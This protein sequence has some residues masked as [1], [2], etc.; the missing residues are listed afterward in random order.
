MSNM[1]TEKRERK[2]KTISGQIVQV[3]VVRFKDSSKEFEEMF[4]VVE[5]ENVSLNDSFM[6]YNPKTSQE[7]RVKSSIIKAKETGM[8]NFRK[9]AMDPSFAD[10][11]KTIIYCTGKKPAVGGLGNFWDEIFK[12]FIPEKNSRLIDDLEKDVSLGVLIKY[13]VEKRKYKVR[14]AWKTVCVN[15]KDIAHCDNSKDAKHEFEETG[16]R[17]IGKWF[18]LGNTCKIVKKREGSGYLIFGTCYDYKNGNLADVSDIGF[19]YDD[20]NLSVGE[21]VMDV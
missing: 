6:Q 16:S 11:D 14:K 1:T 20:C 10:D 19:P 2:L 12:N 7:K 18:D 17:P 3:K 8:R 4:P 15:S 21:L 13:L 9:A 5:I